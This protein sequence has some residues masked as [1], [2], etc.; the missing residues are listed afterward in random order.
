MAEILIV[1]DI[2]TNCDVLQRRLESSGFKTE[3]AMSGKEALA[4]VDKK[5][6]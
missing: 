2:K 3:V 5:K 1:D 4:A 6:L